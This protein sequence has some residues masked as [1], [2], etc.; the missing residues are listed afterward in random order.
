LS[1]FDVD[2]IS[3]DGAVVFVVDGVL[4]FDDEGATDEE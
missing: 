3:V 1:G 2:G 4:R